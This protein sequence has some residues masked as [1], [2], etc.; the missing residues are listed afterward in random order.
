MSTLHDRECTRVM[1]SKYEVSWLIHIIAT[2][3]FDYSWC[4]IL[5]LVSLDC[6]RMD[7]SKKLDS[8]FYKKTWDIL[9]I[10]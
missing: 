7:M 6:F 5:H 9:A 1:S 8:G 3:F 10:Q 4:W 2:A